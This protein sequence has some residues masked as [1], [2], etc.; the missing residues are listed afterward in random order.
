MSELQKL[1]SLWK[2]TSKKGDTYLAGRLGDMRILVMANKNRSS[3]DEP[4]HVVLL[5]PRNNGNGSNGGGEHRS[6]TF[7]GRPHYGGER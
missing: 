4:T 1:T 6:S 5:A 2:K 7:D 3:D